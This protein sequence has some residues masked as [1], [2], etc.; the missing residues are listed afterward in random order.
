MFRVNFIT[1]ILFVASV[2]NL[3]IF[4]V[5]V[6][7]KTLIDESFI[8][9]LIYN[10]V[11]FYGITFFVY[12]VIYYLSDDDRKHKKYIVNFG[13]FLIG[14]IFILFIVFWLKMIDQPVVIHGN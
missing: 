14:T 10:E 5:A 7:V 12:I 1:A 3:I 13:I 6:G 2:I 4:T 8:K 9:R 11:V